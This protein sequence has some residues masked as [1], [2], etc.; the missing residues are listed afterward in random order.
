MSTRIA[1]S[2]ALSLA[3]A[4]VAN[5]QSRE[6]SDNAQGAEGVLHQQLV[7]LLSPEGAEHVLGVGL[8]T[9][10]GDQD[11]P[12]FG[13]AHV[14]AGLLNY[15]SPIYAITGGWFELSP[16]SFLVLRAEFM[17]AAHWPIDLRGAGYYPAQGYDVDLTGEVLDTEHGR[18]ASG[19]NVGLSTILQGAFP[20]GEVEIVVWN[21]LSAE[22][23]TLGDSSFHYYPRYDLVLAKSD[24]VVGN[25]AMLM[26]AFRLDIAVQIRLGLYDELRYVPRSGYLVNQAGIVA[27]LPLERTD[28]AVPEVTPFVRFGFFTHGRRA[29]SFTFMGGAT[30][31]YR[32]G[33]L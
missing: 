19:W 16:L 8:R 13:G 6:N 5:A 28:P 26:L 11:H 32:L 29:V 3:A 12:L 22:H 18:S 2:L 17:G 20:L 10:I 31:R 24:W 23:I 27:M 4:S 33:A 30:A 25:W 1:L 21:Q 9:S 7:G 14:D 15:S